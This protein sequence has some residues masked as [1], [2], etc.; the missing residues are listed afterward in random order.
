VPGIRPRPRR[1]VRHLAAR[2]ARCRAPADQLSSHHQPAT[3]I[4]EAHITALVVIHYKINN[5][6]ILGGGRSP[7]RLNRAPR[8]LAPAIASLRRFTSLARVATAPATACRG[9]LRRA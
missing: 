3:R 9:T 7:F 4:A 2:P 5:V 1:P 8:D 6:Y